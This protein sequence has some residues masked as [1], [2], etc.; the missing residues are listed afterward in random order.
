MSAAKVTEEVFISTW[1]RLGSPI[2]VSKELDMPKER[3]H[4]RRKT[5]EKKYNITLPTT[6]NQR[7]DFVRSKHNRRIELDIYDGMAV[8]F[9]DCHYWPDDDP[10]A[11]RALIKFINQFKPDVVVCNGDAFDG[12]SISRHPRIG[13]E[14]RPTVKQEID[15][16]TEKLTEIESAG[17]KDAKLFWT[18]GNHDWRFESILAAGVPQMEGV[19]GMS[20]KDH[21]PRWSPCYTVMING[22]TKIKHRYKGGEHATYNNTLRS[23]VNIITNH[24]HNPNVRRYTDDRGARYGVDTGC[25]AAVDGRQFNYLEDD[26]AN[27]RSGFAI[28]TFRKGMLLPP[29]LIEVISE[30]EGLV[31]F[32]GELINV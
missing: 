29:E 22:D 6:N 24:L 2:L 12:A 4:A 1:K 9:G 5:I 32:R 8:V 23:G 18:L 17:R 7:L 11:H 19:Y 3:V 13:F 28:L 16:V 15:A 10:T 20:L 27:W 26:T 14:H 30:E 21:F 25:I 31:A